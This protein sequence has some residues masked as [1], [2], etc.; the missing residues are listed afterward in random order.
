MI[1]SIAEAQGLGWAKPEDAQEVLPSDERLATARAALDRADPIVA[2]VARLEELV[3]GL[4]ERIEGLERAGRS[5]LPGVASEDPT[6]SVKP[7][8][9]AGVSKATYY[10]QRKESGR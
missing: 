2:R 9:A 7:W 10:R 5:A 6:S 8:V 3:R 1:K 4:L